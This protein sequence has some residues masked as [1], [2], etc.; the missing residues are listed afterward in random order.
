[1]EAAIR[2]ARSAE[3]RSDR[4]TFR[5][6]NFEIDVS[7]RRLRAQGGGRCVDGA[8]NSRKGLLVAF[9]DLSDFYGSFH[10][11]G[12]NRIFEHV[13]AKRP[14]LFNYGTQWVI[15]Q[16]DK[17]MC[18]PIDV[19]PEVLERNNPVVS[20]EEH[21]PI[22]GTGGVY[23]LNWAMQIADLAIDIHPSSS[24]LPDEFD[25]KLDDQ[26]LALFVKICAGIGCPSERG[27]EAFPPAPQPPF[28]IP[29]S[30][31]GDEKDD[32]KPTEP[33]RQ[34]VTLP[35]ERLTCFELDLYAIAHAELRGP[36]GEQ[37]VELILDGVEVVDITPEGLENSV[38]CYI[39][40]ML[41]YVVMPRLRILLPVFVFDLP[42]GL[43]SVTVEAATG[44]ANNPALEDDQLKV[45]VDME[46]SL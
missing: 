20:V 6:R 29:G 25:G 46:V 34:P 11:R 32:R 10:K 35:A 33:P 24:E 5:G 27:F 30:K 31:E 43:G 36:I 41:R 3:Q 13:R 26:Q 40:A 22:P 2:T 28:V 1:M 14:S 21:L 17:R 44:V 9:T 18:C 37:T 4:G 42:L 45:F 39:E 23:G 19:A 7:R 12:I 16:W 15:D 8:S 38:E